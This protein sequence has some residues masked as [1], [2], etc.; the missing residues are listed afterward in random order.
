MNTKTLALTIVFTALTIAINVAGP[1]IPA[2]FAPFL[3][4]QLWE[5]PIVIAFLSIGIKA[6]SYL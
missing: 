2:P 6:Y 5:I 3:Q 1:K 4:Y